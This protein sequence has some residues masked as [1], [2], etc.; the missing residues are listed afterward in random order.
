MSWLTEQSMLMLL[1]LVVFIAIWLVAGFARNNR[2]KIDRGSHL[3]DDKNSGAV[4]VKKSD[5]V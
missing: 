3:N 4:S 5:K 2:A 1:G